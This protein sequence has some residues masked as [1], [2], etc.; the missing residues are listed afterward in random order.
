MNVRLIVPSEAIPCQCSPTRQ[1]G[2]AI[3]DLAGGFTATQ[4]M[5]GWKDNNGFLVVEPVTVFDCYYDN[6]FKV[7]CV[8]VDCFR[9]L[10][11]RIAGELKQDCVYLSI[12][13]NAEFIKP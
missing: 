2:K 6:S 8:I 1:Y 4:G 9:D 13:G 10:A 5:G 7:D 3:A 12:D 11:R